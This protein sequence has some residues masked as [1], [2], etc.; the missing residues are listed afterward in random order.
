MKKT[1]KPR[2]HIARANRK[3]NK[4]KVVPAAKGKSSVY[5]R[6]EFKRPYSSEARALDSKPE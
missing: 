4:P 6:Q 5:N 3:V 2:N 1:Q